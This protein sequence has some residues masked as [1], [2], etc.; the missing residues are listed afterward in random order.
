MHAFAGV[1]A[2]TAA[3]Y[4]NLVG[5]DEGRVEA[6]AELADQVRI[7]LLVARE[8]LHEIGGA[9][10]GDGAQVGHRIVTAH[11]DTVVF[12]RD[13]LGVLVE[14][15]TN[16]QFGATFQQLRLGQGFET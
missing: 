6:H 1:E 13:G 10:F 16:F 15:H 4:F 11:A 14:A 5:N 8:V 12:D 9:R 7:F 2:G 3:E